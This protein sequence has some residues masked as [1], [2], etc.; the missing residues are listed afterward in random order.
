MKPRFCLTLAVV[1][2]ALIS[3]AP[4]QAQR[5]I[6]HHTIEVHTEA[7][8]PGELIAFGGLYW[9]TAY[10]VCPAGSI[11]ISFEQERRPTRVLG[12]VPATSVIPFSGGFSAQVSLPEDAR[13][14]RGV[15]RFVQREREV[16]GSGLCVDA[17]RPSE[18]GYGLRIQRRPAGAPCT[19]VNGCAPTPTPELEIVSPPGPSH[20]PGEGLGVAG[21]DFPDTYGDPVCPSK[22]GLFQ[23]V[24]FYLTDSSGSSQRVDTGILRNDGELQE[25]IPIPSRG[26]ASGRTV[27]TA[28]LRGYEGDP[29]CGRPGTATLNIGLPPPTVT[30]QTQVVAGASVTISGDWWRTDRCDS[31]VDLVLHRGKTERVLKR[32]KP[33]AKGAF[34]A[35]VKVPS[36]K[37]QARIVAV[38]RRSLEVADPFGRAGKSRCVRPARKLGSKR[39]TARKAPPAPPIPGPIGPPVPTPAPAPAPALEA[40]QTGPDSLRLT[41]SHWVRGSCEGGKANPVTITLAH[42]GKPAEIIGTVTPDDAGAFTTELQPVAVSTGDEATATQTRCDGSGLSATAT[43]SPA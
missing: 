16:S 4:A 19:P 6:E 26:L 35:T 32:V 37:G 41:G 23:A 7:I 33:G 3:A 40:R 8:W 17:R 12:Q 21:H 39:V 1:A 36:G 18:R 13:L 2:C 14:G 15:L 10:G 25:T 34:E 43:V 31:R 11:Q 9:G 42:A 28:V 20:R 27:I 24:W 38:Q 29:V 22:T 5:F 30:F